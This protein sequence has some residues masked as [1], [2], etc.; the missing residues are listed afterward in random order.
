MDTG[1]V[2]QLVTHAMYNVHVHV[3]AIIVL[4]PDKP[5][6]PGQRLFRACYIHVALISREY[7]YM[8]MYM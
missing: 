8:Y 6:I 3:H 4:G 1:E 5:V 2:Q 7:T